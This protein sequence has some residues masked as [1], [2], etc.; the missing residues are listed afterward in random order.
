MGHWTRS[1][2]SQG[3]LIV[4]IGAQGSNS[5]EQLPAV[6][7]RGNAKLL[8]VLGRQVRENRLVYR[9]MTPIVIMQS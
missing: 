3:R 7:Q 1:L 5:I 6:S 4:R 2:L 9:R 8:Q